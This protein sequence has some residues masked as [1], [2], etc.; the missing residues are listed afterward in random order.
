MSTV[1]IRYSFIVFRRK[2]QVAQTGLVAGTVVPGCAGVLE[3]S[4][5]FSIFS[6]HG[7]NGTINNRLAVLKIMCAFAIFC[8]IWAPLEI[9]SIKR[10]NN[11]K[12]K[13]PMQIEA[14][15][16]N[17]W[18]IPVLTACRSEWMIAIGRYLPPQFSS[19]GEMSAGLVAS[20]SLLA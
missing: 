11:G 7:M 19:I 14:T 6:I 18:K 1:L 12:H 17:R 8:S 13:S 5:V 10:T 4:Q 15:L 2:A 3:G 16:D 20:I 9:H